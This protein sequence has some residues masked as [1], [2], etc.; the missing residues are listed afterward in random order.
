MKAYN[1]TFKEIEGFAQEIFKEMSKYMPIHESVDYLIENK[2]LTPR[3]VNALWNELYVM[4]G[5]ENIKWN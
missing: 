5:K 3:D 1:Y 2:N 4:K